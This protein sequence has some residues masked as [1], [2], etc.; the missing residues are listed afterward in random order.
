MP[1]LYLL[2]WYKILSAVERYKTAPIPKWHGVACPDHENRNIPISITFSEM[3][4]FYSPITFTV[5]V[6]AEAKPTNQL[7]CP[8]KDKT[9]YPTKGKD[10][11][12]NIS[13]GRTECANKAKFRIHAKGLCTE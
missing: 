7:S 4:L 1:Q 8:Q 3:V 12:A 10:R 2:S 6:D 13:M 5:K 11:T 9:L